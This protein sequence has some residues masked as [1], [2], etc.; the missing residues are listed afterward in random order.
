MPASHVLSVE[1]DLYLA[2]TAFVASGGLPEPIARFLPGIYTW[3]QGVLPYVIAF[4]LAPITWLLSLF[5][6]GASV[7]QRLPTRCLRPA[8]LKLPKGTAIHTS[9]DCIRHSAPRTTFPYIPLVG[10]I[11]TIVLTLVALYLLVR[12]VLGLKRWFIDIRRRQRARRIRLVTNGHG[13]GETRESLWSWAL[14][15]SQLRTLMRALFARLFPQRARPIEERNIYAEE[16]RSEPTVRSVREIYRAMLKRAARHGYP[17][18][19]NETPY[20]YRQRL[21]EKTPL[22]E[23]RIV[24]ITELY[25]AIRYGGIV[26]NRDEVER[27]HQVWLGLEKKWQQI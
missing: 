10:V 18:L 26:P 15:W 12:L 13:Q 3:L 11:L 23:P 22:A 25:I 16:G 27:I 9:A 8:L 17:R 20:E 7:G 14:F 1:A 2:I 24:L 6:R 19:K 4:L 5:P 21:E